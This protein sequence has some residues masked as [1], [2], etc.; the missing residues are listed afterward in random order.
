MSGKTE[1]ALIDRSLEIPSQTYPEVDSKS[2]QVTIRPTG[3]SKEK[4]QH[5]LYQCLSHKYENW[6][7][8]SPDPVKAKWA[9][10]WPIRNPSA[11]NRDRKYLEQAG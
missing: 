1:V 2:Y 10:L 5:Y 9:G 8:R 4:A 3:D 7:F 11:G 6:E